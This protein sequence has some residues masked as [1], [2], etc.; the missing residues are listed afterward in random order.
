MES[1]V[2]HQTEAADKRIVPYNV[3]DETS[4]E[5]LSQPQHTEYKAYEILKDKVY[6]FT[7]LYHQPIDAARIYLNSLGTSRYA[8]I[9]TFRSARDENYVLEPLSN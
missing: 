3:E 5:L 8:L 2:V 4:G 6:P 7:L 1:Y 9:D